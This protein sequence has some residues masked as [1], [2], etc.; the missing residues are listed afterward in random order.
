MNRY[1]S[2]TMINCSDNLTAGRNCSTRVLA[3]DQTVS[4]LDPL[5]QVS[6]EELRVS[7]DS[8]KHDPCPLLSQQQQQ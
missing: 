1:K 5:S 8:D 2:A 4:L 7:A 3:S 6:A